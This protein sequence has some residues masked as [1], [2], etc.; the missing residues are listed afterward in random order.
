MRKRVCVCVGG[1]GLGDRDLVFIEVD[2][3]QGRKKYA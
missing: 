3:C 1:G 2:S